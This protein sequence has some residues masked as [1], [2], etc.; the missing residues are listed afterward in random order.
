MRPG[1][2]IVRLAAAMIAM[3]I[4]YA[5]PSVAQAHGSHSHDGPA[6][7]EEYAAPYGAT[8]WMPTVPT[9]PAILS[10]DEMPW[11]AGTLKS[12]PAVG[13]LYAGRQV[14]KGAIKP[15]I[16]N[17]GCRP[18]DFM[19]SCCGTMACHGSGILSGPSA[20]PARAF[21]HV[22][23]T[24]HDVAARSSVGPEALPKPPRPLA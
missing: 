14:S 5:A 13:V 18:R 9:V 12:S 17:E 10:S 7:V 23:L 1:R 22:S 24:P 4:A 21:T 16:G 6:T 3:I 11:N 20:L 8:A 2:H 19:G 15:G